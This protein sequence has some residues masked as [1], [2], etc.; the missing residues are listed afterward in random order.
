MTAYTNTRDNN[1]LPGV[2]FKDG[3]TLT[4]VNGSKWIWQNESWF[5][6][7]FAGNPDVQP[8][9]AQRN[10][11]GGVVVL[12]PDGTPFSIDGGHY[13]GP[14]L[15]QNYTEKAGTEICN[16]GST[17][18]NTVNGTG[19]SIALD[20][21]NTIEELV[22]LALTVGTGA[23][24]V[25]RIIPELPKNGQICLAVYIPDCSKINYV[26]IK[27]GTTGAFT[28]SWTYQYPVNSAPDNNNY[29]GLHLIYVDKTKW[30]VLAGSPNWDADSYVRV[31]VETA[32]TAGAVLNLG[33]IV[34]GGESRAKVIWTWD[35][36]RGSMNQVVDYV[37]GKNFPMTFYVI[38]KDL[39]RRWASRLPIARWREMYDMGHDIAC[40]AYNHS[41]STDIGNA[42][43]L[44]D[45][46]N[47]A[48]L[49]ENLGFT[50]NGMAYHHAYVEGKYDAAL[51]EMF[52]ESGFLTCRTISATKHLP[53][54]N[55]IVNQ[56][57]LDGGLQLNS[58]ITLTQVKARVDAA[59][60]AG[61]SLII[62]GHD[63]GPTAGIT[64]WSINDTLAL[65]D[66]IIACGDIDP[67]SMSGWYA[68]M[69]N[70]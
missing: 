5:P 68:G 25:V 28:T 42:A 26:T 19:A 66:Y 36:G 35:D 52:R 47:A 63:V 39:Y 13:R 49:L 62:T 46:I 3:D 24:N 22:S 59:R 23:C 7:M 53:T 4:T 70:R 15:P 67:M 9:T 16:F 57:F 34:A 29:N 48:R 11:S 64:M 18:G 65:I 33:R 32:G 69:S 60:A 45:K 50:R 2:G 20:N 21:I 30:Q 14:T 41:S 31:M 51:A 54:W 58:S 56:H 61:G 8:L 17:T 27:I 40:H 6:V 10:S 12:G 38:L 43:Y 55:G 37:K 44:A 1:V